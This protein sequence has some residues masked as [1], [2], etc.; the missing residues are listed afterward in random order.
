MSHATAG[1]S[2]TSPGGRYR[3]GTVGKGKSGRR[4]KSGCPRGEPCGRSSLL[5]RRGLVSL[6]DHLDAHAREPL[7]DESE[8]L[9]GRER[10]VDQAIPNMGAAIVDAKNDLPAVGEVGHPNPGSVRERTMRRGQL[11]FIVRFSECR[12]A[13]VEAVGVVR[14]VADLRI[15]V[16]LAGSMSRGSTAEDRGQKQRA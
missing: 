14:R 15:G 8:L 9:G 5:G 1:A 2:R 3:S 12:L 6:C 11:A 13:S 10:Y 4:R 16:R 7:P